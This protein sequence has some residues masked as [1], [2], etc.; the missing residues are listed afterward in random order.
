MNK[1]SKIEYKVRFA[2]E[3]KTP[4]SIVRKIEG[5]DTFVVESCNKYRGWTA[6]PDS[7]SCWIGSSDGDWHSAPDAEDKSIKFIDKWINK[8]KKN[9]TN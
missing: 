9:W 3:S 4:T 7:I 6:S 2:Y 1:D 8:W 5:E